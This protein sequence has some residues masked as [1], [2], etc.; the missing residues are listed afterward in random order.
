VC[1]GRWPKSGTYDVLKWQI[2]RI[3]HPAL[4]PRP[5]EYSLDLVRFGPLEIDIRLWSHFVL[6]VFAFPE[7]I[8]HLLFVVVDLFAGPTEL[9]GFRIGAVGKDGRYTRG[10]LAFA[11]TGVSFS[12][13]LFPE[14]FI[15]GRFDLVAPGFPLTSRRFG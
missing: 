2:D 1:R 13:N 6:A 9:E 15:L 5:S 8:V 11:G 10:A 12:M 3:I 7:P 4:I 14:I